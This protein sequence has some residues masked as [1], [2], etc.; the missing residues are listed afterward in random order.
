MYVCLCTGVTDGQIR[1]CVAEGACSLK[2]LRETLG[3]ATRCGRCAPYAKSLL[4]EFKT[5][6]A[7]PPQ[8]AL[9]A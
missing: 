2:D 8:A 3:V 6:T 5:T 7:E 1:S 9:A 4:K